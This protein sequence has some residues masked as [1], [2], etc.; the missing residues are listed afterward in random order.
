MTRAAFD[1][2]GTACRCGSAGLCLPAAPAVQA[3]ATPVCVRT[4]TGGHRQAGDPEAAGAGPVQAGAH[5]GAIASVAGTGRGRLATKTGLAD[6]EAAPDAG[7]ALLA[8]GRRKA[9]LAVVFAN[10]ALSAVFVIGLLLPPRPPP[11]G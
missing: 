4:R 10:A 7:L 1:T 5:V 8:A 2:P 9:A 11:R 6:R 3:G